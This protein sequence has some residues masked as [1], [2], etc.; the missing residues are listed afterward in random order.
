M[1]TFFQN[2][3]TTSSLYFRLKALFIL[4]TIA[5]IH[6]RKL[7][8]IE[9]TNGQNT[10]DLYDC[11]YISS[12]L[13]EFI[14]ILSYSNQVEFSFCKYLQLKWNKL[15]HTK[16]G[17]VSIGQNLRILLINKGNSD[18]LTHYD[19]I[20]NALNTNKPNLCVINESNDSPN[21]SLEDKFEDFAI[22]QKFLPGYGKGRTLLL[23][24]KNVEYERLHS[25]ELPFISTIWLKIKTDSNKIIYF[26]GGYRCWTL[27][28]AMFPGG[29]NNSSKSPKI[30]LERFRLIM[31]QIE[32]VSKLRHEIITATDSNIDL[33]DDTDMNSR[34]NIC[35]LYNEF[36]QFLAINNL[37]LMNK[38]PTRYWPGQKPS[39]LDHIICNQPN[40]ICN[41]LT[42]GGI[43]ADHE[44]VRC[45]YCHKVSEPLPHFIKIRDFSLL[46]RISILDQ[47]CIN[48]RINS[49]FNYSN[50]N[51]VCNILIE[52][53]NYIIDF[54]APATIKPFKKCYQP[55]LDQS[56]KDQICES[57]QLLTKAITTNAQ[58]D[59]RFHKRKRNLLGKNIKEAKRKY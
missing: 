45:D 49:I 50:P 27:P 53:L 59:W 1:Q 22:E 5:N 56:L 26:M 57:E 29:Y 25:L 11:H 9:F 16:N 23:I 8:T 3:M 2:K 55:Y 43:I 51:H 6:K 18:I 52:E 20:L 13:I 10:H 33:L 21:D 36:I 12:K 32:S 31:Q 37:T 39:L 24:R 28:K 44:M 54:L 17:N 42:L 7:L 41:I 15:N 48:Q 47:I 38:D 35:K 14:Y 34:F 4:I 58:E 40:K 46:T 19:L 30:Q